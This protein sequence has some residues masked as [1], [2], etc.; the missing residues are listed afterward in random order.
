MK[1][2]ERCLPCLI[3]QV[4]K[5]AQMTKIK[6]PQ[7]LYKT[8]FSWM[9]NM[10]FELTN[11]EIIG[12]MFAIVKEYIGDND[13]YLELRNDYNQLFL[14]ME[15]DFEDQIMMS[16]QPFL[17]AI[18]YAIL[19][20][21]IDFHAM[22]HKTNQEVLKMFE[23]VEQMFLEIDHTQ[24]LLSDLKNAKTL[25][26]LGDNCGEICLDKILIKYIKQLN[27]HLDIY[28]VTRGQPVVNDSIESDAYKV[29]IHDYAKIINNG[30]DSLGTILHRTSPSFL[31]CYEDVDVVI[32]K[33]QANYESLSE[34][35]KNIYFL[36]MVKC[37]VISEYIGVQKNSLVCIKSDINV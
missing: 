12:A 30:D 16:S 27:P 29:G 6:N 15:K 7:V 8:V 23:S 2:N 22:N 35:K 28:F 25:M 24:E 5:I 13:P 19:G 34:E 21:V 37:E 10:D 33:G 36:L 31:K 3:N 26:Y 4:V 18:K 17:K 32:S 9:S 1:M 14:N 11:P 20:N